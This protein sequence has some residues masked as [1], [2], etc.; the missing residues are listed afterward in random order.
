[1]SLA[2]S[3]FRRWFLLATVLA[4]LHTVIV[5]AALGGGQGFAHDRYGHPG[6]DGRLYDLFAII[7]FPGASLVWRPYF[8]EPW[9]FFLLL[10]IIHWGLKGLL[11]QVGWRWIQ[12]TRKEYAAASRFF[13]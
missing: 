13:P 1:M 7:D 4:G 2:K 5:L 10:G 9:L 6:I 8:I 3:T 11:I 12:K